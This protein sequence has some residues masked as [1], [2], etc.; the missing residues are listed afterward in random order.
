LQ[1]QEIMARE[2]ACCGPDDPLNEVAKLMVR[3]S[4]NSVP[5]VGNPALRGPLLG[6][7][8]DR[9]IVCRVLAVDRNPMEMTAKDCMTRPP[10]TLRL[11]QEVQQAARLME[12]ERARRVPVI[13]GNGRLCGILT[14]AQI[15]RAL[16]AGG[17]YDV[18]SPAR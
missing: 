3:H 16:A 13:D 5:V 4:T 11:E 14:Q 2:P 6:M 18:P 10:V 7:L 1:V 17:A 9:D 15:T 8:T 12:R